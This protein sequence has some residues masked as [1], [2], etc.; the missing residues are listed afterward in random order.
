M[1]SRPRARAVSVEMIDTCAPVSNMKSPAT[2]RPPCATSTEKKG[3]F[4][5]TGGKFPSIT[6]PSGENDTRSST[7]TVYRLPAAAGRSA[8]KS[9][10]MRKFPSPNDSQGV[11]SSVVTRPAIAGMP[12]IPNGP[13]MLTSRVASEMIRASGIV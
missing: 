12:T 5:H 3:T 13:N 2:E 9:Q 11:K 4:D 1:V 7:E 6:W 10:A 8:P